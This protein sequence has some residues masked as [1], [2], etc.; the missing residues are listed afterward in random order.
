MPS[1]MHVKLGEWSLEALS[2]KE[3]HFWR[4]AEKE[5]ATLFLIPDNYFAEPEKWGRYVVLPDGR[6]LPHGPTDLEYTQVSFVARPDRR[7]AAKVLVHL[8]GKVVE[9]IAAGNALESARFAGALA[10]YVQDS[11]GPAHVINNYLLLRLF[12]ASG[13]RAVHMHRVIDVRAGGAA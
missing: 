1:S 12:P 7:V 13:R 6:V 2:R 5:F 8:V 3:R 9:R 4:P 11:A 10:H